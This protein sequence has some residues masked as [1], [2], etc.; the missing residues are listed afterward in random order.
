MKHSPPPIT[1]RWN[2]VSQALRR[3]IDEYHCP[4]FSVIVHHRGRVVFEDCV[5]VMDLETGQ[6]LREDAIFRIYSMTKLVTSAALMTLFEEGKFLLGDPLAKFI[7]S[8]QEMRV[9]G[10][11]ND[12]THTVPAEVPITIRHL[13]THTSGLAYGF[14]MGPLEEMARR[15]GHWDFPHLVLIQPLENIAEIFSSLPLAFQ[16]GTAWSYSIAYDLVG[17]LVSLISGQPFQE[18]LQERLFKPLGMPDTGFWV[19]PEKLDRLVSLYAV[20]TESQHVRVEA[21]EGSVFARPDAVPSGGGGLVSTRADYLRFAR[22]LLNGGELDGVRLL[23]PRT[24]SLMASNQLTQAQMAPLTPMSFDNPGC[25]WGLGAFVVL[26]R[27]QAGTLASNGTFGW[28]GSAGTGGFIDPQEDL[29][30][31]LMT[32]TYDSN[33]LPIIDPQEHLRAVLM[34]LTYDSPL[35]PIYRNLFQ[36][37]VYQALE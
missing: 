29:A 36:E 18:Y 32:Q 37:L 8:F 9:V 20:N 5:G 17:Y 12:L 6:P 14:G 4:G 26:D 16:P 3:W 33:L 34:T 35:P 19:P 7:P 23:N 28:G 30:A 10:P 13:L 15:A 24:V 27:A 31:V 25:G 2:R 1:N 21:A 22:M 11:G